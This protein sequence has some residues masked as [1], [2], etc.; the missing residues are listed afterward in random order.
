MST[1][2]KPD[3]PELAHIQNSHTQEH[4]IFTKKGPHLTWDIWAIFAI[5]NTRCAVL[6]PI[7]QIYFTCGPFCP[8]QKKASGVASL[9]EVA[10]FLMLSG[11]MLFSTARGNN[12]KNFHISTNKDP[13]LRVTEYKYLGIWID[14]KFTFKFHID[15]LVNKCFF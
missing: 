7:F 15:N 1:K 4:N 5:L 8:G 14:D 12:S 3:K 11:F 10:H 13:L 2:N 9:P 6:A